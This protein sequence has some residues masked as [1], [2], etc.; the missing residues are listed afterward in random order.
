MY[1]FYTLDMKVCMF[2]PYSINPQIRIYSAAIP[3]WP[4]TFTKLSTSEN[5]MKRHDF[6]KREQAVNKF[7]IL[8]GTRNVLKVKRKM[9]EV[10]QVKT[11]SK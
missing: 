9:K 5:S 10:P 1:W 7:Y 8:Q 11:A 6:F 4:G 3:S 2:H